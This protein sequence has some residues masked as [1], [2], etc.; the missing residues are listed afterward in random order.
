MNTHTGTQEYSPEA[1]LKLSLQIYLGKEQGS[2]DCSGSPICI[3]VPESFGA[4][5]KE[6][7]GTFV[8]SPV[9]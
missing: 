9:A 3:G 5:C 1:L 8:K 4:L 6:G 7:F 2:R